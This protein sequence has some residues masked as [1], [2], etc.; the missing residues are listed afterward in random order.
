MERV[1]R[2]QFVRTLCEA[3]TC[4]VCAKVCREYVVCEMGH[5]LCAWCYKNLYVFWGENVRCQRRGCRFDFPPRRGEYEERM[6]EV[7][8]IQFKCRWINCTHRGSVG[9]LRIHEESC[10][11]NPVSQ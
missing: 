10:R 7:L 1:Y 3:L 6:V 9:E 2:T 4:P 11:H 5:T 8:E